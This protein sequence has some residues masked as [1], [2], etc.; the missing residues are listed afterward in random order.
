MYVCMSVVQEETCSSRL[1]GLL[2]YIST[3][4]VDAESTVNYVPTNRAAILLHVAV[5]TC[6]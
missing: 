6:A 3:R 2:P 1:Y 4:L 5:L